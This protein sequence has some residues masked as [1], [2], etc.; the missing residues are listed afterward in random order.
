L[1]AAANNPNE[2][3]RWVD[4]VEKVARSVGIVLLGRFDPA[5]LSRLLGFVAA[6]LAATSTRTRLT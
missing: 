2:M 1:R 5:E 4:V 6:G 3:S